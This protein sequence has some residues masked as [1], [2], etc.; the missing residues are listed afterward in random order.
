MDFYAAVADGTTLTLFLGFGGANRLCLRG[1]PTAEVY[2]SRYAVAVILVPYDSCGVRYRGPNIEGPP[3]EPRITV[4][5][6]TP[7]GDRAVLETAHIQPVPTVT[8]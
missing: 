6:R 1:T 2:E 5:L 4:E 8:G 7:L 3:R